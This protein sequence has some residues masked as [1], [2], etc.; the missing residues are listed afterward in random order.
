MRKIARMAF[1]WILYI[2]NQ[3]LAVCDSD[4]EADRLAKEYPEWIRHSAA[5][6]P[7]DLPGRIRELQQGSAGA[8][9]WKVS[10]PAGFREHLMTLFAHW[11]AAGGLITNPKGEVLMMFRRGVWDLPKGKLDPGETLETCALREVAEETGLR[12]VRILSRL[13]D[14]WHAYP[15]EETWI[16]KQ[17]SWY[18]MASDGTEHTVAQ[19]EE[20]ILDIQWVSPLHLEKYLKFTYTNIRSVF[21][22]AGMA[23]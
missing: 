15:L 6:T 7:Q 9:I 23:V 4:A 20:D 16:L 14:T 5:I 13:K 17:T 21:R 19:I 8:Q 11:R 3:A 18:R 12:R 22:D 2:R 10:D 1:P